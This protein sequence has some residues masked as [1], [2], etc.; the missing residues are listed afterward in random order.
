MRSSFHDSKGTK[1][2]LQHATGLA[3][4]NMPAGFPTWPQT[5]AADIVQIS[6]G[7]CASMC[8]LV[9]VPEGP[10]SPRKLFWCNILQQPLIELPTH[11]FFPLL[12]SLFLFFLFF[13]KPTTSIFAGWLW[14]FLATPTV[15]NFVGKPQHKKLGK[16]V[17]KWKHV[18]KPRTC[19]P[20]AITEHA[21]QWSTK[22]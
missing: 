3:S 2:G 8:V 9:C 4:C 11:I 6:K 17:K 18:P 22:H 16:N 1:S 19:V 7:A 20:E 14:G 12:A 5:H 10:P 15:N 13:F 21:V